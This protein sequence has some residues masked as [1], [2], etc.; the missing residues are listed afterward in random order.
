MFSRLP[1]CSATLLLLFSMAVISGCSTF[2]NPF[3]SNV[4]SS[5]SARQDLFGPEL[6]A[7]SSN[8]LQTLHVET[9]NRLAAGGHPQQAAQLF[10]KA[11]AADSNRSTFDRQLAPLFAQIKDFDQAIDRYRRA[12]EQNPNDQELR[13]NYAWTLV[14]VNRFK[15]AEIALQPVL[16]RDP[17]HPRALSTLAM[18]RFLQGDSQGAFQKFQQVNGT[19]A[20]RHNM[21]MLCIEHDDLESAKVW[22]QQALNDNPLPQTQQLH[23]ALQKVDVSQDVASAG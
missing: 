4:S 6:A 12:I 3:D 10:L 7:F 16:D 14:E 21:A 23:Q 22:I 18:A 9:A 17:Q 8:D 5:I 11:E 13:V 20:A 15:E 1:T 19:S 2:K